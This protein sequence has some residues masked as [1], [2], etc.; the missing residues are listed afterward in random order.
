MDDKPRVYGVDV[1]KARL[2][3]GDYECAV[4][5]TIDNAAIQIA[6]WLSSIPA[7]SVVAME[8]TGAYH[9]LL[10]TLAHAAGMRVFV[11]NPRAL[12]HYAEAIGQRGK[13]DP[14]D[15]RMIAR[16]AMHEQAKLREWQPPTPETDKLGQ[17]LQRRER[18]VTAYQMLSQS[19]AGVSALKAQRQALLASLKR[20]I[21]NVELL[22]RAEL[23]HAPELDQLHQ[24]LSTI[25]GVGFVVAAQL[26]AALPRLRFARVESFIAYTGLDPRPDD[27]GTRR[28][29]RRL[30]KRGPALLR[31][32][33]YNAGMAAAHSKLFK[34]LY[35][36]LRA[37][38]L[39]ST[40]AIVILA[41][42][43]ARIAF[44]LYRSGGT[45]DAAKHLQTA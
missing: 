27:S 36:R 45:F 28:G 14:V 32:L 42:K 17:L 37:R 25:V 15:T 43:L 30:T 5:L 8:A 35:S 44:A 12:K 19:L 23:A 7:G 41:R 38:G 9:Q 40:E 13:T 6:A 24:R 22:M 20:M 1:A 33:L 3:M 10:A 4:L 29:R 16:Y 39:Q 18:L 31:C 34:P 2:V 21:N 26:V 11:L